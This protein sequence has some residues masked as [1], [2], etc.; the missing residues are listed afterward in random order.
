MQA[1]EQLVQRVQYLL[2]ESLADLILKLAAVV[3]KRRQSLRAR[4]TEEAGLPK[5]QAQRRRNRPPR[6]LGHVRNTEVNPARTLTV[7]R[8]DKTKRP[9]IE[10]HTCRRSSLPQQPVQATVLGC[11]KSVLAISDRIEVFIRLKDAYEKL[12]RASVLRFQFPDCVI[13]S[14]HVAIF[15]QRDFQLRRDGTLWCAR[16]RLWRKT[17]SHGGRREGSEVGNVRNRAFLLVEGT[18][19]H[20]CTKQLLPFGIA[21]IENR[22]CP[23][24]RWRGHDKARRT[25]EPNPFK[26]CGDLRIELCH[27]PQFVSGQR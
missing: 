25:H 21:P 6:G 23:N 27:G 4:Q 22:P 19:L 14:K 3:E 15:R 8:R 17:P 11:F 12:P 2:S 24:E 16:V 7:R 13:G 26:M 9:P 10:K 18:L 5:Q 20:T 1:A